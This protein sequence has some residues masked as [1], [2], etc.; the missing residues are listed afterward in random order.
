MIISIQIVKIKQTILLAHPFDFNRYDQGLKFKS[1]CN[2]PLTIWTAFAHAANYCFTIFCCCIRLFR[3]MLLFS[4]RWC[5]SILIFHSS[6]VFFRFKCLRSST[7]IYHLNCICIVVG[8][9]EMQYVLWMHRRMGN[10]LIA[11][12]MQHNQFVALSLSC[13]CKIY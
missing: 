10:I 9:F 4:S 11:H 6:W 5:L 2:H 7:Q 13:I 3:T 12:W 1:F 8:H